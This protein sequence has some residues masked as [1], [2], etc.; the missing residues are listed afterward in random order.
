MNTPAL[1]PVASKEW[2]ARIDAQLATKGLRIKRYFG[3]DPEKLCLNGIKIG[4]TLEHTDDGRKV[5]APLLIPVTE[6]LPAPIVEPRADLRAALKLV[7]ERKHE[8]TS[9]ESAELKTAFRSFRI[10]QMK[11]KD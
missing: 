6:H 10:K 4:V 2:V 9:F 7:M 8:L 1:P 11:W 3:V 5:S